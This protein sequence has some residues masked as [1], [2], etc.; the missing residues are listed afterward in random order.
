[1]KRQKDDH[2]RTVSKEEPEWNAE[3]PAMLQDPD[4]TINT[5]LAKHCKSKAALVCHHNSPDTQTGHQKTMQD[6][7]LKDTDAQ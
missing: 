1:M 6:M 2:A 3:D 5:A 7:Q 4:G